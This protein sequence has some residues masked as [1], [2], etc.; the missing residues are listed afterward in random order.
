MVTYV[1]DILEE[2]EA[3]YPHLIKTGNFAKNSVEFEIPKE[4]P[5]S[6]NVENA[7]MACLK[8]G[9]KRLDAIVAKTRVPVANLNGTLTLMELQ[10]KV[11]QD[12]FGNYFIVK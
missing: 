12:K 11:S 5:A 7:V 3:I 2:Y 6:T 10:G 9:P 4:G 1:S 8:E